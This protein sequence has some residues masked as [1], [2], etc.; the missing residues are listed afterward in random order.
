[1]TMDNIHTTGPDLENMVIAK[2][3]RVLE[4]GSVECSTLPGQA[5][6]PNATGLS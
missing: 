6:T 3:N 4:A 5:K 1:M 2:E